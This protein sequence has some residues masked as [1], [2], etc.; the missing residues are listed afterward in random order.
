MGVSPYLSSAWKRF[1]QAGSGATSKFG[2]GKLGQISEG[3]QQLPR[4]ISI[5]KGA[6]EFNQEEGSTPKGVEAKLGKTS[7][8]KTINSPAFFDC[9]KKK[10]GKMENI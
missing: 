10:A 5:K 4:F 6:Q 3:G 7:F 9:L 2:G 1:S 8:N